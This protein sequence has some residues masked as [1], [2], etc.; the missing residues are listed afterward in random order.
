MLKES[1]INELEKYVTTQYQEVKQKVRMYAYFYITAHRLTMYV[2]MCSRNQKRERFVIVL[3]T[4]LQ[5]FVVKLQ[6]VLHKI[7]NCTT[8]NSKLH[9][10]KLHILQCTYNNLCIG[11]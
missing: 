3:Q 5:Y 6:W 2:R 4:V 10:T 7:T 1:K 8:L 11:V 9:Y